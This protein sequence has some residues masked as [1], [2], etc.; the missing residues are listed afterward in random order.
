MIAVLFVMCAV[1]ALG[2]VT[3]PRAPVTRT[4][5]AIVH[6]QTTV[7]ATVTATKT[8]EAPRPTLAIPASCQRLIDYNAQMYT[9][10]EAFV[11]AYG[12]FKLQTD[13]V[14]DGILRNNEAIMQTAENQLAAL[15]MNGAEALNNI[16]TLH[17]QA[18]TANSQCEED[19]K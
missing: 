13:L 18:T 15:N 12:N 19:S 5:P 16:I 4:A 17:Y 1:A 8:V 7:H 11:S 2:R 9:A 6:V 10:F 14:F 3:T